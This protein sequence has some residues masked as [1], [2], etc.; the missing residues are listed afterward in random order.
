MENLWIYVLLIFIFIVRGIAKSAQKQIDANKKNNDKRGENPFEKER[1]F[2]E[3]DPFTWED[4]F[5]SETSQ[6]TVATVEESGKKAEKGNIKIAESSP[7]P[8]FSEK[9][10]KA[11]GKKIAVPDDDAYNIQDNTDLSLYKTEELRKA[12]VAAEILAKKF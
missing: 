1:E 8:E 11:D 12:I 5:P 4:F 7:L 6:E 9:T 2:T 10:P 3:N